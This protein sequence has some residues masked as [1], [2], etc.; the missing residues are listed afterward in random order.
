MVGATPNTNRLGMSSVAV[1]HCSFEDVDSGILRFLSG[2]H[3]ALASVSGKDWVFSLCRFD[4]P[5][6]G[7]PSSA[8]FFDL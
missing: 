6:V 5:R 7:T 4:C 8:V 1:S 2:E 3:S